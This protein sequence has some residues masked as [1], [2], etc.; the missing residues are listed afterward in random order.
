M[1]PTTKVN[2]TEIEAAILRPVLRALARDYLMDVRTPVW[3]QM[4]FR[5]EIHEVR[6]AV[7]F[8][9]GLDENRKRMMY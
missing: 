1:A 8:E 7:Y 9:L 5:S 2:E 3:V 6:N 4:V